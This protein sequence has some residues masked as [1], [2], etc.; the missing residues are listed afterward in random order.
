MRLGRAEAIRFA[1]EEFTAVRTHSAL[2][3]RSEMSVSIAMRSVGHMRV[4]IIR[5]GAMC[6]VNLIANAANCGQYSQAA[7]LAAAG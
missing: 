4:A 6:A 3:C 7:G 1:V 2:G 5:F